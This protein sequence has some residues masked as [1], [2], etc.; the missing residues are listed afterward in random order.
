M[1][2]A[3]LV[4][5]INIEDASVLAEFVSDI[6]N[7]E[8]FAEALAS[9][10]YKERG[11]AGNDYA[12]KTSGVWAVPSYRLDGKELNAV[13]NV[14]VTK[15]ELWALLSAASV[16]YDF[17]VTDT[18]GRMENSAFFAEM[19]LEELW[20]LFPIEL[21]EHNPIWADWYDK[22][23]I[24]LLELLGDHIAQI[25]HIGSTAI[26]GLL[27]KPIVDIL[28][29]IGDECDI[30]DI[31][32]TLIKGG[33]LLMAE[34]SP[35]GELDLNKGYTP[36]GFANKVFHLHVRRV[37]DW[38]ELWFRDYLMTHPEEI[39][40]YAALKQSLL[41]AYKY[42]RDAYSEG[43]ADFIHDC[44]LKARTQNNRF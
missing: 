16:T 22:E 39:D 9:G 40:E 18:D 19:S 7:A 15:E 30:V 27:A 36:E 24:A 26:N 44:V 23:R 28:L 6:V 43:K 14:G 20:R 1:F 38:D 29:Q 37:G 32:D 41:T 34:N 33:W 5:Q 12:Y 8:A 17:S 2:D 10:R 21:T 25:G 31:R 11:L 35:Y 13:E 42:N 4:S 3:A